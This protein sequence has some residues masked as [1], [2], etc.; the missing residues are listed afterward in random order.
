MEREMDEKEL[1]KLVLEKVKEH[2]V[3]FISLWFTDIL[4]FLKS[5]TLTVDELPEALEEGVGFDGSSVEG[6]VRIEE[7]DMIAKPDP[8]TFAILPWTTGDRVVGRMFCDIYLPDGRPFEGD[9]RYVLKR[10]LQ[11][12]KEKG[13]TYYVGPELEYFYFKSAESIDFLD[14][15][16]YFDVT[17]LDMAVDLKR[18]TVL[19]LEQIGIKVEYIHHEVAYSQHEIDI[20][21]T[22]ALTMAD[23]VMTYK[24]VVKRVALSKGV[25]ATFMPKPVYGINGSGMH[26]HQ[27]LFKD[28]KNAFFAPN[29]SYHLS[30]IGK[31]FI[32]GLLKH[33][34]EITAIT[35]QWVNSYKR[36]IPGFEAPAYI[37]WGTKNRSALVRVPEYKPGKEQ[38][39]RVEYRAPDPACNPYLTFAVM[40]AA[41]LEGIEKGYELPPP[42]EV[43]VYSLTEKEREELGIE[44]LPSSLGEAIKEMEKS[45][46][47]RECLGEHVFWSFIRNKKAEWD[48]YRSQVTEYEIKKYLPIL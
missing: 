5:I 7:S 10:M 38:A 32:A 27:S 47:V 44:V 31:R 43:D 1:K 4:G 9:P 35:C 36:L 45:T 46:L 11:K 6:F 23:N 40:L 30:E 48:E 37:S 42:V 12:A 16:G 25:Y 18:E 33:A 8:S 34:K 39:T 26:C 24:V 13:F 22:D 21:Y 3:R 20:K 29:D 28:G 15:G 41:G 14:R 2:N 19:Y 17:P